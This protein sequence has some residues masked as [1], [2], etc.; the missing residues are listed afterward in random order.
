VSYDRIKNPSAENL[1]SKHQLGPRAARIT[2]GELESMDAFAASSG[3]Y[4]PRMSVGTRIGLHTLVDASEHAYSVASYL[5]VSEKK[6]G[7][8]ASSCEKQSGRDGLTISKQNCQ[9]T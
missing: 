4:S 5:R 6:L 2:V 9:R 8:Y 7:R 3:N 1:A